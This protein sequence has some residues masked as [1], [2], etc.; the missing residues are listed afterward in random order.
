MSSRA[1]RE[2]SV[3]PLRD[4]VL[5]KLTERES[6]SSGGIALPGQ[7]EQSNRGQVVATG[8]GRVLESG[9]IRPINVEIGQNVIFSIPPR[10][11][12]IINLDGKDCALMSEDNL[13][14]TYTE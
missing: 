3:R 11:D 7:D 10:R 14:A 2:N 5:V 12:S 4:Q 6:V 1:L 8:S 9:Q 13:L